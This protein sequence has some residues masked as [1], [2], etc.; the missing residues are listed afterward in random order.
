MIK[1]LPLYFIFTTL[2]IAC[3]IYEGEVA[4]TSKGCIDSL[5]IRLIP[6]ND[7]GIQN[8]KYLIV[9]D[10][11]ELGELQCS[12]DIEH[13]E[14]LNDEAVY[15]PSYHDYISDC[16]TIDTDNFINIFFKFDFI[17]DNSKDSVEPELADVEISKDD[18]I[19]YSGELSPQYNRYWC[20]A[21]GCDPRKNFSGVIN[22]QL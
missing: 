5:S 6:E 3:G 9:V 20:N 7:S 2:L 11:A 1:R 14:L 13:G 15:V 18:S 16:A 19:I 17:G 21:K 8:G 10:A 22:V 4:C 12:F